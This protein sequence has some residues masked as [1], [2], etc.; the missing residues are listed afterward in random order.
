[1]KNFSILGYGHIGKV[2]E[3]AIRA[4]ENANLVG[5]IDFELPSDLD[6]KGYTALETFLNED[7]ESDV[8]VI[9]TPNGLHREHAIRCLKGGKNVLIEK[10][11]ALTKEDAEE[12]LAVANE[13]NLRVFSSM[14]L[15]FS[16]VVQYVKKLIDN[17]ALGK[18]HLI[19]IQCYWNRNKA[20]YK[21]RDWHGT[22]ELDGGVLFT[23]FSHFVDVINY[24]FDEVSCT[25]SKS[26]NFNHTDVTDFDD[27]GF[28]EF[29]ADNAVGHMTYTTSV[30]NKN[31]ESTITI[32]AEKGTIKIGG[33]YINEMLYSDL[34]N[35]CCSQKVSTDQK[36]FHLELIDEV[37]DALFRNNE[38]ILDAKNAL[39]LV[40][41]IQVA[42]K[43]AND[44]NL[45]PKE[46]E[47]SH[48]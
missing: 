32:I 9:A 38:S 46:Y 35:V 6:V 11:L 24:W 22:N 29:T 13:K 28:V 34:K 21:L 33:Q 8:V 5:I 39:N 15:R 16:P 48:T 18:I 36:N 3:Q 26:F 31:F 1:M 7:T 14:Q 30:F 41:F 45:T 25:S 43:M 19:N 42:N 47:I 40:K 12:I 10:P 17:K 44:N 23:Q 2:H 4:S 20:Y 27:S 37:S